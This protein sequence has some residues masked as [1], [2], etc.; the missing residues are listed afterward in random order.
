MLQLSWDDLNLMGVA[1]SMYRR[2]ASC[3]VAPRPP[4]FQGDFLARKSHDV[5]RLMP[6]AVVW[7]CKFIDSCSHVHS[8]AIYSPGSLDKRAATQDAI[9][10]AGE[11][12][13]EVSRIPHMNPVREPR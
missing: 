12:V 2:P 7:I 13:P 9:A 1:I 8:C 11:L 5:S 6:Q 3:R 10:M 4:V